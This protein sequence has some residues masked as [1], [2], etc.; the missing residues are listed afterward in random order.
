LQAFPPL[1]YAAALDE[2]DVILLLPLVLHNTGATPIIVLDFRLR[3]DKTEQQL[4]STRNANQAN[5]RPLPPLYLSWRAIQTQLEP[6]G[7]MRGERHGERHTPSPFPVDGRRAVERFIEFGRR[8]PVMVPLNGPYTAIVEVRLAHRQDWRPLLS[9]VLHTELVEEDSR[10][11]YL[12]RSND[13][14]W[15]P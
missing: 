8:Q 2:Q 10:S 13:P 11:R 5:E 7:E 6:A 14:N 3:I 9:F 12:T 15:E 1:S 4:E